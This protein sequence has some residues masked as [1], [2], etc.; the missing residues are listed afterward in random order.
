MTK[1]VCKFDMRRYATPENEEERKTLLEQGYIKL[2]EKKGL[3][4][5]KSLEAITFGDKDIEKLPVL[6]SEGRVEL[7]YY[8]E[9]AKN[10]GKEEGDNIF[11]YDKKTGALLPIGLR[12]EEEVKAVPRISDLEEGK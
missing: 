5:I 8:R 9:G 4:C 3:E 11:M 2:N 7:R 1:S 10:I 12:S 6:L